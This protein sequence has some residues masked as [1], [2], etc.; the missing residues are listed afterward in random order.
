MRRVS[1]HYACPQY[2]EI[3]NLFFFFFPPGVGE[4]QVVGGERR[5]VVVWILPSS[6]ALRFLLIGPG[7][8]LGTERNT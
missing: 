8:L 5:P 1:D 2:L 4:G 3:M 6:I 7:I